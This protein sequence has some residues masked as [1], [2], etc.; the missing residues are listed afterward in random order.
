M[1]RILLMSWIQIINYSATSAKNS[2]NPP[3]TKIRIC[4]ILY[5]VTRNFGFFCSLD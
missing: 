4:L 3:H 1:K 5:S 2:A